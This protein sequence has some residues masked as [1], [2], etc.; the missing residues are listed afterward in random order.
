[1]N[2][3]VGKAVPAP[4]RAPARA[5]TMVGFVLTRSAG[6]FGLK[7]QQDQRS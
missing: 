5:G 4:A 3:Q 2:M 1:M 6:I 7:Q